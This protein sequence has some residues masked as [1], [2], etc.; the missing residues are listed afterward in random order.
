MTILTRAYVASLSPSNCYVSVSRLATDALR[1]SSC[2]SEHPHADDFPGIMR[3]IISMMGQGRV[4]PQTVELF[5][6]PQKPD[7]EGNGEIVARF[8][9]DC[10][11]QT[12]G[13]APVH[14]RCKLVNGSPGGKHDHT[15]IIVSADVRCAEIEMMELPR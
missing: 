9:Y 6:P 13:N 10:I 7:R 2:F 14:F 8:W 5:D 1:Q 15:L 12:G 4:R 3:L 11:W